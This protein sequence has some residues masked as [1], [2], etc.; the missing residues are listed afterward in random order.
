MEA[1]EQAQR[2]I[3]YF[4]RIAREN[5]NFEVW[6]KGLNTAREW[7]RLINSENVSSSE[8]STFL[9]VIHANRYRTS[10][11]TDLALGA[12]HWVVSKGVSVPP[13]KDFFM[14]DGLPTYS[15][16]VK[17]TSVEHAQALNAIFR[18]NNDED[19]TTEGWA[20]GLKITQDWIRLIDKDAKD[21]SEIASLVE[22]AASNQ[23]KY[24]AKVWFDTIL[25]IGLWCKAIGY[26]HLV[27]EDFKD[28]V[29]R[30]DTP[31][32]K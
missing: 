30:S 26:L 15:E 23:R 9:G 28:I 16:L 32:V 5:K 2:L 4:D 14:P 29:S 19:P 22:N 6:Q 7:L 13:A 31:K 11:W 3:S 25:T 24:A 8:L 20:K 10:G 21:E 18:Q 1:Q 12:Y 17:M 27:P